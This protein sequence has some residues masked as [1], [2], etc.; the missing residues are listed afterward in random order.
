MEYWYLRDVTMGDHL[1]VPVRTGSR[2]IHGDELKRT[3]YSVTAVS[4][5]DRSRQG[6][7]GSYNHTP[8]IW[9]IHAWK[10]YPGS[11]IYREIF[12]SDLR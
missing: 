11:G 8:M 4:D 9:H 7:W 2:H 5:V 1:Y 6:T 3:Q 12:I 10:V